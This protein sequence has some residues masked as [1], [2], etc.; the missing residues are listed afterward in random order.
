MGVIHCSRE[1]IRLMKKADQDAHIVNMCS[2]QG[3]RVYVV[4]GLWFNVYSATKHAVRGI[5]E[6]LTKELLGGK[7][8]VTVS[9]NL[10][11]LIALI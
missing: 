11:N 6:T 3:H 10:T 7:I 1:A 8:R 9:M 5:S 4:P 2:I